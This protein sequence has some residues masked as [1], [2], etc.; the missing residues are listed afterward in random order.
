MTVVFPAALDTALS[1][2]TPRPHGEHVPPGVATN[3]GDLLKDLRDAVIAIEGVVGIDGAGERMF[4]RRSMVF[5]IDNGAGVTRDDVMS[6]GAAITIRAI[7]RIY[8]GDATAGTVA[9]ATTS[10]G[11][12]LAGAQIVAAVAAT[13]GAVIGAVEDLTVITTANV[14]KLAAG[15]ELFIRHTG[16]ATTAA[17]EYVVEVDYTVD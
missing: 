5:N 1:L 16:I 6:F 4:T 2:P 12:A 17:G 7:R 14:H 15:A 10:V 3:G 8:V 13:N 11:T 9:S